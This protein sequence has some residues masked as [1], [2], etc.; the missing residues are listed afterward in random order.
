MQAYPKLSLYGGPLL[1]LWLSVLWFVLVGALET[2]VAAERP[3]VDGRPEIRFSSTR[4]DF[5][6]AARNHSILSTFRF[7]NRGNAD[8]QIQEVVPACGC[9]VA[10]VEPERV[11]PGGQGILK[12]SVDTGD[13][14][15]PQRYPIGVRTN[16]PISPEVELEIVGTVAGDIGVSPRLVDFGD[17]QRGARATESPRILRLEPTGPSLGKIDSSAK[18]LSVGFHDLIG[19]RYP[20]LGDNGRGGR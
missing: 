19:Q 11:R 16:D 14:L 18:F 6:I 2:S 13:R 7:E 4:Q 8:L 17:L 20:R 5:G 3:A 15:G 10:S 1:Y 9:R 12:L